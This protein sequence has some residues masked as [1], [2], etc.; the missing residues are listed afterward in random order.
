[1][2]LKSSHSDTRSSEQASDWARSDTPDA[3]DSALLGQA[4]WEPFYVRRSV[5]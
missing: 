2:S 3:P 4:A 1:V 5:Q